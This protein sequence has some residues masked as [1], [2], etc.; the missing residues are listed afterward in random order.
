M[1]IPI[2]G[3]SGVLVPPSDR[4]KKL[5]DYL[6]VAVS[7]HFTLAL[8][9]FL[10]GRYFDGA[11]DLLA[12][13]IGYM[14]IRQAEGYSLQQVLCYAIFCGMEVFFSVIRMI[15]YFA[16]V[17]TDVPT[18]P[19]MIYIYIGTLIAAPLVYGLSCIL[20]YQVYKELRLT[21]IDLSEGMGP[22]PGFYGGGGSSSGNSSRSGSATW[23][24]PEVHP[25]GANSS[26]NSSSASSTSS[27]SDSTSTR[28]IPG[29]PSFKAFSGQGH[30]LGGS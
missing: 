17:G 26:V 19:W 15:M 18:R 2:G 1:C 29:R 14:S 25:N 20:A 21:V 13:L 28:P 30:R 27:S 12:S 22:P 9:M 8:F 16:N 11:F 3:F 24:H 6:K 7:L 5:A 4:A 23:S 10:G